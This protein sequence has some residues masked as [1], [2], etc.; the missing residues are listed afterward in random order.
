MV[1]QLPWKIAAL[2]LWHRILCRLD[3]HEWFGDTMGDESVQVRHCHWCRC[4]QV[5]ELRSGYSGTMWS[6]WEPYEP[7]PEP[8]EW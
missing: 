6:P 1:M 2:K 8:R 7:E 3:R 5:S 4:Y